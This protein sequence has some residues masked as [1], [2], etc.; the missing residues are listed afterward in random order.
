MLNKTSFKLLFLKMKLNHSTVWMLLKS[1]F[2]VFSS[3][4]LAYFTEDY[5]IRLTAVYIS[6]FIRSIPKD[7]LNADSF[8]IPSSSWLRSNKQVNKLERFSRKCLSSLALASL[9]N[10]FITKCVIKALYFILKIF[11]QN[12]YTVS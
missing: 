3:N 1:Y 9:A 10:H 4:D 6:G 5:F 8:L 11:V 2:I 7:N 12:Y